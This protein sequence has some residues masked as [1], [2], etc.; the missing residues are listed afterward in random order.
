[1]PDLRGLTI[2]DALLILN[3]LGVRNIEVEG[4]G[5]VREQYP[6]PGSVDFKEQTIILKLQ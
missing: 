3:Q 6:E 2:R 4:V 1:M 5:R